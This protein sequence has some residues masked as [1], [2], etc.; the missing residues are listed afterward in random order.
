M[1]NTKK[2]SSNNIINGTVNSISELDRC[3]RIRVMDEQGNLH[4]VNAWKGKVITN[5]VSNG[6]V[7]EG[8]S[9]TFIGDMFRT[10][11]DNN[12]KKGVTDTMT[13]CNLTASTKRGISLTSAKK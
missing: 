13:L 7:K 5:L 3:Y 4:T 9:Y 8:K 11:W 12:G 10:E 1:Y 6:T 2:I